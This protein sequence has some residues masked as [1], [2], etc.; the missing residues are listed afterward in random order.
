MPQS[1]VPLTSSRY[2]SALIFV[3]TELGLTLGTTPA[4]SCHGWYIFQ[5][6][7][8]QVV[9]FAVE[10]LLAQR[11]ERCRHQARRRDVLRD[12]SRS[13][14]DVRPGSAR[15]IHPRRVICY[16]EHRHGL[17]RCARRARPYV[18]RHLHCHLRLFRRPPLWVGTSVSVVGLSFLSH[19]SCS[20]A[21]ILFE[22]IL[23]VLTLRKCVI[24]A[25]W[26]KQPMYTMLGR[27]GIWA[28]AAV[29][30]TP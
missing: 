23:L 2:L 6:V 3:G 22:F 14:C 17:L 4:S 21:P 7:T 11:G 27:D 9:L 16:R 5:A 29:F 25:R 26:K 12:T 15:Q 8:L 18:R 1:W 20:I 10:L 24:S 28:F 13:V 30:G 19:Q